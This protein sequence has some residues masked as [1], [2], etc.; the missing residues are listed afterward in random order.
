MQLGMTLLAMAGQAPAREV[1][2][3]TKERQ[4]AVVELLVKC[5][6]AGPGHDPG[7]AV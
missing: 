1:P 3:Y 7:R 4:K 2:V 5:T 6:P